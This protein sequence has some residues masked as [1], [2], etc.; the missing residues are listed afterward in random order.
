MAINRA[1]KRR[2]LKKKEVMVTGDIGCTILGM[3]PPFRTVW[4][5]VSMGASI[6][7]AQGYV[8][9]GIQTPVI[10]TIGDST[11]FHA[12]IPALINALQLQI[13]LTVVIMDNGWTAMTGMQ[14]NPGTDQTFQ[15]SGNARV[16]IARMISAL[17][18]E[19]FFTMDPFDLEPSVET[20]KRCLSLPGVK[21]VLS[22]RECAIQAW[23]RGL[24]AGRI[25]VDPEKCNLCL[26]CITLTGCPA[27]SLG[28]ESIEIDP[29]Q[30]YGCA[31]CGQVCPEQS[32]TKEAES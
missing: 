1:I 8:H 17:G 14:A 23:R 12:G 21:V 10:A 4:N 22:R 9:G 25:H 18:V 15:Q 11:F 31:L 5:E 29:A 6:G 2:G 26:K 28:G 27:I 3:N 20:I 7:L 19:T 32:I 30:C 13:P 16:D 24:R